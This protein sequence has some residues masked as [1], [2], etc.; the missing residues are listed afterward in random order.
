M[1]EIIVMVTDGTSTI[2]LQM[3]I[4]YKYL[5]D[6]QPHIFGIQSVQDSQSLK[7]TTSP[8]NF[9]LGVCERS[10][11]QNMTSLSDSGPNQK[12]VATNLKS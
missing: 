10:I 8:I 2:T 1:G 9:N 3:S 12:H 11:K 4:N 5:I 6:G 7:I